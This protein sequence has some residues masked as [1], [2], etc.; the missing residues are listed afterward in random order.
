VNRSAAAALVLSLGAA[1]AAAQSE[2]RFSLDSV[3]AADLF[4]GQNTAERPNIVVDITAVVRLGDGWLLYVRPWFRQPRSPEWDKEIYQAAMQYE[5]PGTVATRI[6]VGYIVSPIGLGMMDT[7]PGVNPTI[8]PHLSYVSTMPAFDPGAPRI[9]PIASTYPLGGQVSFSTNRWDARAAL[10]NSA[11][12]RPFV[13][14]GGDNPAH[15]PVVIAGAGITPAF[16]LR[17]GVSLAQGTYV[18][19]DEL[20]VPSDRDRGLTMIAFE[21]EYSFGYTRLSGEVI[22]DR[23]E[24]AAGTEIAYTWFVQGVQTI[25]PRWFVAARLEGASAPPLVSGPAPGVRPLFHATEA[26]V[27]FRLSTDFTLRGS[28]MGRKAYTR[29][30]VDQQ[31][32]V[33]VVW[34]RR[35][36]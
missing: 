34:A 29:S 18:T 15:T 13:I 4:R 10:V 25:S 24:T 20:R 7:R 14:N 35:W 11:P 32:G 1:P 31:A 16:G 21:G 6:D 2:A 33:S 28:F 3:V 27:G 36:W 8:T 22:R 17:L 12:T 5:R 23:L 19:A 30:E 9:R 26:T